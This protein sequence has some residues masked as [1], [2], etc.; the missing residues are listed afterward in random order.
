MRLEDFD[1]DED[2]VIQD[3]LKQ[4]TWNE[5]RTNDSWAIFKIMSEFVNGYETM[6][7]IGPCVTIFGSARTQHD[8]KYYTLAEKIAYKISKAGYGIITGGGPGIMEA[9]NKGAHLGGGTSVGLNI[10]LPFEQHF[11]PYIDRDKNLNFDYFFVRKVMFVKYSQGF[12]VMPGGFGTLDELFEAITLIQTKK[13]AK[14]P[15]IL[16]G[17]SFWS[18]LIDWIKNVLIDTEKTVSPEDLNLIKIVD[19]EDEVVQALDSFY[20]KY[21]LSPNF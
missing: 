18:G 19:N 7:R 9:G 21:T 17:S 14:F 8:T 13:I 6:G 10:E 12:V 4:K 15:I 3:K 20:K 11:N 16:V 5:I 1:N 2:K